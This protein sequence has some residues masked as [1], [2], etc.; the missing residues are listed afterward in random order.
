MN[1]LKET[2]NIQE[3]L[4]NYCKT[5]IEE[6]I[7]GITKNR[8]HHY[9][10]LVYNA[11]RNTLEQAYPISLQ[12]LGEEEFGKMIHDFF[13]NHN[14]K[15]P[16]I[17]KLPEEFY[18][19]ALKENFNEKYQHPWMHD[20]LLFE[21]I[22]IEVHT[23]PDITPP[24]YGIIKDILS[25]RLIINS[26]YRLIKLEYPVHSKT[27]EQLLSNKGDYFVLIS[28]DPVEGKVLF[29]NLSILHT[30]IF[31]RIA[32]GEK[33]VRSLFKEINEI[34]GVESET[35]LAQNLNAFLKDLHEKGVILGAGL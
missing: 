35:V 15:T 5:G 33:T 9:R 17:W 32:S 22:E 3:S 8:V 26:E 1:L 10:R 2:Y 21:W 34:F 4:G 29:F 16:Q 25:E 6:D 12:V 31:E 28:R 27:V 7:P 24:E 18:E 20:M 14:C 23:M 19:Y 30:W 11:V 13:S